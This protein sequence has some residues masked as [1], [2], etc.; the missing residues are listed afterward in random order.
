MNFESDDNVDIDSYI[1]MIRLKT[2][3]LLGYSLELGALLAQADQ[4]TS[5]QLRQFGELIGI[6]FQLKDDLLD[7]YADQGKFGKQVGGDIIANKKTFLLLTALQ[8]ADDNQRKSLNEWIQKTEFN[9]EEKVKQV[10]A[11]YDEI[12]IR[13]L[14]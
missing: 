8:L 1:E 6:G 7:V 10:T 9:A 13:E 4:N 3:V 14:N 2:A 11:I 5:D 12:G